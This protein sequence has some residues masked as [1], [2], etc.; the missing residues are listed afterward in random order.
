MGSPFG[1][2]HQGEI[3]MVMENS[4]TIGNTSALRE[5]YIKTIT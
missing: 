4:I 1:L 5:A 3:P 2:P